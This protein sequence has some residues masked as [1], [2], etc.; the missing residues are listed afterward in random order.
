MARD[1]G[2][3]SS[4]TAILATSSEALGEILTCTGRSSDESS[5]LVQS[6]TVSSADATTSGEIC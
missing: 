5:V 2:G 4:S 3:D 1:I 6:E